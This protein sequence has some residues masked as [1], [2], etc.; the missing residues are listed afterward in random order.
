MEESSR[1]IL[2]VEEER[3]DEHER[4]NRRRPKEPW[5]GEYAKSIVYGGLDAIV[6]CFSLISSISANRLSSD[7]CI[8][9]IVEV[10][11]CNMLSSGVVDVLVLGFANLVADGISMGFG[12]FV[13]SNTKKDTDAASIKRALTEWDVT[14]H[15]GPQKMDLLHQYQALGMDHD[16]ATTVCSYL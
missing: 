6:T 9:Y 11:L 4:E 10:N 7:T 13:S 14:N 12:N 5:K 15:S 1:E 8:I 16:D 2:L 3:R